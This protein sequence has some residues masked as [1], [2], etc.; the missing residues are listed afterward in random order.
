LKLLDAGERYGSEV[1]EAA[2]P[3]TRDRLR[4]RNEQPH[5]RIA[6]GRARI[7]LSLHELEVGKPLPELAGFDESGDEGP[8]PRDPFG[9]GPD[10]GE[11]ALQSAEG[12]DG[13]LFASVIPVDQHH[14]AS[15]R[16]C[17]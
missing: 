3:R 7:S 8:V 16:K 2:A 6:H 12:L 9:C 5:C 4:E 11:I 10:S 1:A 15:A 13:L 14:P 17:E